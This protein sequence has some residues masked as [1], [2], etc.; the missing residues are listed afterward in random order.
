[1]KKHERTFVYKTHNYTKLH[2]YNKLHD[3]VI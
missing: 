2:R 3:E 1:M